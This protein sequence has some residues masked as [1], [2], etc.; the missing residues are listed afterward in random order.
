MDFA[1]LINQPTA[2]KQDL[3]VQRVLATGRES[4]TGNTREEKKA[5]LRKASKEFEAIFV[6]QMITAMRKTINHSGVINPNYSQ[7][8]SCTNSH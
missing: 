7:K 1:N 3:D 6:Y 5:A 8:S 4:A 2:L